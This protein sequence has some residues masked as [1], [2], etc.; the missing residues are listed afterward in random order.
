M[1]RTVIEKLL[2]MIR[3]MTLAPMRLIKNMKML[4][5]MMMKRIVMR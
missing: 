3:S 5:N 1:T 2:T 4:M